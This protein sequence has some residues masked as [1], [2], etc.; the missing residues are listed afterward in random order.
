[1]QYISSGICNDDFVGV[2]LVDEM[3]GELWNVRT[4]DFEKHW[5]LYGL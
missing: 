4:I 3:G 2:P 1:M 5:K